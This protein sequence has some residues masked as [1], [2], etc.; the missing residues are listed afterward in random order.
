MFL[1]VC[2]K[3]FSDRENFLFKNRNDM[4]LFLKSI[5]AQTS[6]DASFDYISRKTTKNNGWEQTTVY[7]F[8]VVEIEP[9]DLSHLEAI[10]C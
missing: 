6:K 2:N 10:Y 8:K 7:R 3:T 5:E 9:V 1:L 4:D